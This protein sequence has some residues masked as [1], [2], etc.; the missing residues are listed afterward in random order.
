MQ[1]QE[2]HHP[3]VTFALPPPSPSPPREVQQQKASTS[4]SQSQRQL[5]GPK[6]VEEKRQPRRPPTLTAAQLLAHAAGPP[7]IGGGSNQNPQSL[8]SSSS[9]SR[10]TIS[11]PRLRVLPDGRPLADVDSNTTWPGGVIPYQRLPSCYDSPDQAQPLLAGPTNLVNS[12]RLGSASASA[13]K[14]PGMLDGGGGSRAITT[15]PRPGNSNPPMVS[16]SGGTNPQRPATSK[17]SFAWTWTPGATAA[18]IYDPDYVDGP[19][20]CLSPR[21]SLPASASINVDALNAEASR[22]GRS[23]AT[24]RLTGGEATPP[25][26]HEETRSNVSGS[27]AGSYASC[28]S[29]LFASEFGGVG[30]MGTVESIWG[31]QLSEFRGIRL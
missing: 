17:K 29:E 24:K 3:R 31:E 5:V 19:P 9:S 27:S 28:A 16:A 11:Y 22:M 8:G 12:T 30:H 7:N 2:R 15:N 18:P 14:V 26:E 10:W 6:R 13:P 1:G 4:Q 21:P 20:E 25:V 23:A